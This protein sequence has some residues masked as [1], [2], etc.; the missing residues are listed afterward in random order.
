MKKHGDAQD[1][2]KKEKEKSVQEQAEKKED[3]NTQPPQLS[4]EE[5]EA[6]ILKAQELDVF[7]DKFIR[8]AADFENAKKRL[9]KERED[10]FKYALEDTISSLLPVLD[11]FDR[12]L[13]HLD[14][15][16]NKVKPIRDGFLLIQKQLLA[17]LSDRG[18]KRIEVLEKPFDPHSQEAVAHVVDESKP[19]GTVVEEV[20]TGY[21]L[22]GRLI[23]AAK[24]KVSD[25]QAKD[26]QS[27]SEGK[28]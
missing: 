17:T 3:K 24:V 5:V 11:N 9:T 25:K 19:E 8:S 1:A 21:E 23:R 2:K 26:E 18:L 22:N 16:D 27:P 13:V 12:A 14:E 6:L 15:S 28:A 7:K 10:F 20:L 4:K